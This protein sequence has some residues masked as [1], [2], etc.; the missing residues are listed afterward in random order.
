M[1]VPLILALT[2]ALSAIAC[3][4]NFT[5][6]RT[7]NIEI[8]PVAPSHVAITADGDEVCRLSFETGDIPIAVSCK[9]GEILWADP[10][11]RIL[12]CAPFPCPAGKVPDYSNPGVVECR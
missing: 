1:R 7:A 5:A 4:H 12:R 11:G 9:A 2:I 10:A 8:D 3:G 6:Q